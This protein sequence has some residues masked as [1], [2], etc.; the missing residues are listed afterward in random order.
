VLRTRLLTAAIGIPLLLVVL[1]AGAP[2]LTLLLVVV[3]VG[4]AVELS[5]LLVK[6]GYPVQP[7]VVGGLALFAGIQGA[8]VVPNQAAFFAAWLVTVFVVA[9]LVAIGRPEPGDGMRRLVG[10]LLGAL[11]AAM[12]AF[13][14][15]IAAGTRP[16]SADGPLLQWLDDGRIWLLT[17]VLTV[18]AYDTAAYVTGRL[19]PRGAFFDHI[20][21]SKTWSGAVGGAAGAAL[22]GLLLG[23]VIGRPVQVFGLGVLVG[24][25]APVGDLAESMIK[26]AAGVKDSSRLFPGHGGLLDRLDSFLTVAPAAWLYLVI[27][28]LAY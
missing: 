4:A 15:R 9:A 19:L 11:A 25:V 8:V 16:D 26:R 21:P 6:A 7:E 28:G 22:A 18:W 2:W 5:G 10:T 24:L 1:L 3:V 17:V 23:L 13:L 27:A 20:S 12:L 14:L